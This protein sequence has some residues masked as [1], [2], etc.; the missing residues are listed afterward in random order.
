MATW[1]GA[2]DKPLVSICCITYNHELYI[3]DAL[4][5]FLI[6][7]T[8][9]PFEIL[10]HDDA[11]T[12]KTAEIIRKYEE[13]Y[14]LLFKTI[15]Q[16]ENKYSLGIKPN[17]QFNYPRVKGEYVALCEGDDCWITPEKLQIQ[18]EFL[19]TNPA[20]SMCFHRGKFEKF[21][22]LGVKGKSSP[23]FGRTGTLMNRGLFFEGGSSA[24]TASMVFRSIV[25]KDLPKFFELAPVGDMPLK[26]LCALYGDIGYIDKVMS[27]RRIGVPGSWNVRTRLIPE[28]QNQYLEAM[29]LMLEEFNAFTGYKWAQEIDCKCANYAAQ[30]NRIGISK[31]I[32]VK[33]R[34]PN[35]YNKLNIKEKLI[36][37]LKSSKLILKLRNVNNAIL[38]LVSK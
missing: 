29:I 16:T 38:S 21:E 11:S 3:E 2:H 13:R 20:C 30:I 5:G 36:F 19:K 27:I 9:F 17:P 24:P 34:Y 15:F 33:S 31:K 14:P 26:L 28:K 22:D 23:S 4:E 25:I 32:N 10:V 35:Y 7:K 8:D 1:K 6:Q 12:D 18:V 37:K